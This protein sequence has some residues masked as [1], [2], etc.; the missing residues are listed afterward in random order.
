MRTPIPYL[1]LALALLLP[2][3]ASAASKERTPDPRVVGSE[4]FLNAHPDMKYRQTGLN[5]Y[6]LGEFER[7]MTQF[8]RAARYADK[9]S[10]GMVAE[11]LWRG[12]GVEQD[13]AAAYAWMDLAAERHFRIMLIQRESY[14]EAL[15]PEERE[16]A[17]TIGETLYAE[18]GDVVAKPRLERAMRRAKSKSTGSRT[19]F[20]GNLVIQFDTPA[21]P[22]TI[23][24]STYYHPD[25]WDPKRY[26]A[27]QEK[28]WK[29][30]PRGVVDIGPLQGRGAADGKDKRDAAGKD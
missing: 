14:W 5:A 17:L 2:L 20:V 13:R 25:L 18:M 11:M 9:P 22:V 24:G 15:T 10:Q 19:G 3:Q 7:A 16:L 27:W 29:N 4:G 12:E 23:D 26:W 6:E 8:K 1:L 21:G 30:P 28:H